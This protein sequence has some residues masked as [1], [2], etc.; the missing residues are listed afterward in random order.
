MRQLKYQCVKTNRSQSHTHE[1][2]KLR[3]WSHV[4]EKRN[5]GAGAV[6]FLRWLR[7]PEK[8]QTV[9]RHL[10]DPE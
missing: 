3:C 6:S 4:H 1:N 9:A 7:S 2:Q 5:S 8:I 10:D